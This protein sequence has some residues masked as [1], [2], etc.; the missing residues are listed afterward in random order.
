MKHSWRPDDGFRAAESRNRAIAAASSD[1]IILIDGDMLL[2]PSFIADHLK[3][4]RKGRLIQGS[5]V[6]LTEERTAAL[7]ENSSLP[8]LSCFS[9]G[10][11]KRTSA[12]RLRLQAKSVGSHGNRKHKGIKTCNMGFFRDDALAVNGFNNEFVGW[13]REDSEFVARCYHAGMKRHN[14]K[15]A[16]VAYHLWHHEAERDSLPQNDALLQQTL[17]EGKIRCEDGI[18]AFLK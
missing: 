11:R 3:L 15:F 7:L 9:T 10:I 5:R 2:D 8:A 14:L 1:Y 18:D 16:G 6:I 13:G 12:L 4:A 17:F